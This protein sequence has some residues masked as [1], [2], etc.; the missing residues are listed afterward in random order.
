MQAENELK[1]CPVCGISK[2]IEAITVCFTGHSFVMCLNCKH[3]SPPSDTKEA[4]IAAWN[5]RKGEA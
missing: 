2:P 4:A 5:R 3:Q 1:A